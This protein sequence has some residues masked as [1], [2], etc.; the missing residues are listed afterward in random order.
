MLN[1]VVYRK[2]FKALK[3][4][5]YCPVL[6]HLFFADGSLIF[7]EATKENAQ[8]VKEVLECYCKASGEGVN[9]MK[10]NIGF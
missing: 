4:S 5:R 10:S 9:L 8:S 6:S 3:M 7:M 1:K 2:E